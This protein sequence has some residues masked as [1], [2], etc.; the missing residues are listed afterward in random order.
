MTN[1]KQVELDRF[2]EEIDR[3]WQL[4]ISEEELT[5]LFLSADLNKRK[6]IINFFKL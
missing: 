6:E 5:D 1:R 3:A 2:K 4:S